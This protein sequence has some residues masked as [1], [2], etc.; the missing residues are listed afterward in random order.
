SLL[1]ANL[2]EVVENHAAFFNAYP[3]LRSALLSGSYITNTVMEGEHPGSILEHF[4]EEYLDS[5]N[6]NVSASFKTV[7]LLSASLKNKQGTTNYWAPATHLKQLLKDEQLLKIYLGLLVAK[8]ESTT[9][10]FRI[11]QAKQNDLSELIDSSALDPH[12][13]SKYR[14]YLS[15]IVQKIAFIES[16]INASKNISNDSLKIENY[17]LIVSNAIDLLKH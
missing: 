17:Y 16:K 14:N 5:L 10:V 13:I 2:P 4:P 7:Q 3:E 6:K 15:G 11:V 9:I 12:N 1:P 8:K